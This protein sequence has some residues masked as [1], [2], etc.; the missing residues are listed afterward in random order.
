MSNVSKIEAVVKHYLMAIVPAE[1]AAIVDGHGSEAKHIA[2]AAALATFGPIL[3]TFWNK[4]KDTKDAIAFMKAYKQFATAVTPAPVAAAQ[5][6]AAA[7]P[8][9]ETPAP[10]V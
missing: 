7:N 1:T 3:G 9:S 5:A 10:T 2:W 6:V 4:Y 8:L